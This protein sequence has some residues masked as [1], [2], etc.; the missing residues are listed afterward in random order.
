M[1][2]LEE[3]HQRSRLEVLALQEQLSSLLRP[4][5]AEAARERAFSSSLSVPF[6]PGAQRR[7]GRHSRG[8][9]LIGSPVTLS[10]VELTSPSQALANSASAVIDV[11]S[12]VTKPEAF[13]CEDG[14]L[15]QLRRE[16]AIAI[17]FRRTSSELA[18][19]IQFPA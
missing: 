7:A 13:T 14:E 8:A 6:S 19:A 18:C 15:N 5:S 3:M 12:A 1:K 9:S 17:C 10:T 11:A 4:S 2:S 16:G